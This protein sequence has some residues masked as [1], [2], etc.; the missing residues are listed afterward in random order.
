MN[1]LNVIIEVVPSTPKQKV[2]GS[3]F[4]QKNFLT[5]PPQ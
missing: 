1:G 4:I 3:W 5:D 2:L